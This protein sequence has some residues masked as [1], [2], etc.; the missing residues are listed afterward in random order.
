M[1]IEELNK[2]DIQAFN[3][4]LDQRESELIAQEAEADYWQEV[5]YGKQERLA[6]ERYFRENPTEKYDSPDF[7]FERD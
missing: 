7:Y 4:W 6:R 3:Q 2:E 5:V 1:R